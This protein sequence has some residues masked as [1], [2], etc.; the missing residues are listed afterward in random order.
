MKTKD[1]LLWAFGAVFL[2]VLIVWGIC[3]AVTGSDYYNYSGYVLEIKENKKNQI[4][5]TTI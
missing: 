4:V 1:K 2:I 5:L 3:V